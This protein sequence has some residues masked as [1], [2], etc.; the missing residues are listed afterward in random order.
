MDNWTAVGPSSCVLR[1]QLYHQLLGVAYGAAFAALVT[2]ATLLVGLSVICSAAA[3][4]AAAGWVNSMHHLPKTVLAV[5]KAW[6]CEWLASPKAGVLAWHV[7]WCFWVVFGHM[8]LACLQLQCCC[9]STELLTLQRL[10][11][12][13]T[14]C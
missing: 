8:M 3:T 5:F 10:S 6:L 14:P 7:I 11:L 4:T 1:V 9:S 12:A 13:L 2:L